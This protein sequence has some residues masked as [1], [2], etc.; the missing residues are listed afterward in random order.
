MKSKDVVELEALGKVK[1][2]F[3]QKVLAWRV[4]RWVTL[5]KSDALPRK[6]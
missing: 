2:S 1:I 3:L 4:W 6:I 5:S